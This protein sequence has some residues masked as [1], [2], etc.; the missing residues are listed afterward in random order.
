MAS[1]SKRLTRGSRLLNFNEV[2]MMKRFNIKFS[3]Y[4]LPTFSEL[5]G[6]PSLKWQGSAQG[7]VRMIIKKLLLLRQKIVTRMKV[8]EVVEWSRKSRGLAKRK[9]WIQTNPGELL[10]FM[11]CVNVGK[12]PDFS[13]FLFP[14]WQNLNNTYFEKVALKGMGMLANQWV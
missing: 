5:L 7:A 4:T 9:T 10:I 1:R 13:E 8:H 12:H 6:W 14:N 2:S 11:N 3:D